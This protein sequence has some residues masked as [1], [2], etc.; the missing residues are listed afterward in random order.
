MYYGLKK[1][2]KIHIYL[3]QKPGSGGGAVELFESPLLFFW[4]LSLSRIVFSLSLSLSV[5]RAFLGDY[6]FT[7]LT[8]LSFIV[9]FWAQ[10][11]LLVS[12]STLIY[13]HQRR[14]TPSI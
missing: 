12:L 13:T 3:N 10:N 2:Q 7:K 11:D 6:P 1:I 14:S 9:K 5:H 4:K 8:F